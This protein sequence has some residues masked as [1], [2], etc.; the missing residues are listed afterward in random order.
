MLAVAGALVGVRLLTELLPPEAYGEL[1][2]G[3]TVA[4]LLNQVVFGPLANGASRFYAVAQEEGDIPTYLAAVKRTALAATGW[5]LA[6][7][8]PVAALMFFTGHARWLGLAVAALAFGVLSGYNG[9]LD[10]IQNAARQRLV[11]AWHQ[12]L[13]SWGRFV[14]AAGLI[15]V[16]GSSS[17]TA[18]AGFASAL[19]VVLA[20]QSRFLLRSVN[21]PLTKAPVDRS[22]ATRWRTQVLGYSWPFAAWGWLTWAQQASDRWFLGLFATTGEVGQYAVLYQLGYYPMMLGSGMVLQLIGP[23][24][25]QRAGTG[26]DLDRLQASNRVS[27]SL[28]L[29]TGVATLAAWGL[30]LLL[31]R[32]LFSLLAGEQYRGVS[33]FLPWMVLA[34]GMFATGQVLSLEFM[35]SVNTSSLVIPKVATALVG[36]GLN[37]TGAA[38][39]GVAGVVA[40]SVVWSVAYVATVF[41]YLR[42]TEHRIVGRPC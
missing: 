4:T 9:I 8:I 21:A 14:L 23:V 19:V 38:V 39:Y 15:L 18:M 32:P 13:A 3:T 31:H 22:T 12:G 7:A 40:A 42:H 36:I 10:A 20:S 26:R 17:T 37:L 24:L 5:I 35:T 28:A 29:W 2:L 41:G 30:L 16:L 25:F 27:R 1:A 34:G 11:V 6:A 33:G